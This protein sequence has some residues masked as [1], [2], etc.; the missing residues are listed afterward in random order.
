MARAG[1]QLHFAF[2]KGR[3]SHTVEKREGVG[4]QTP[5]RDT[6]EL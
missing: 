2:L 3:I 4:Q 6:V 1:D 5:Q